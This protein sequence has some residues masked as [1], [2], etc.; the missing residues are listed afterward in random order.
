MTD[1]AVYTWPWFSIK[2]CQQIREGGSGGYAGC[3]LEGI[4]LCCLAVIDM[5][6]SSSMLV[7][8]NCF[9]VMVM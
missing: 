4:S 1:K 8:V 3:L 9:P 5:G 6:V 7:N 2:C